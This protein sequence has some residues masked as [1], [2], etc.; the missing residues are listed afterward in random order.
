L[1]SS[2]DVETARR[3]VAAD[4]SLNGPFIP[5]DATDAFFA[6]AEPLRQTVNG[7]RTITHWQDRDEISTLHEAILETPAGKASVAMSE[8]NTVRGGRVASAS[9]HRH[10]RRRRDWRVLPPGE[11]GA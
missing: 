2:G 9:A 4:L 1:C 7:L 3:F 5:V 8:S 10:R 11:E 6:S